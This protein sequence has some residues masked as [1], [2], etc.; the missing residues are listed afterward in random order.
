MASALESKYNCRQYQIEYLHY[1]FVHAPNDRK[2]PL[3]LICGRTLQNDSMKPSKFK[4]HLA[5]VHP[6]KNTMV[7]SISNLLQKN[8][9]G[10]HLI[11]I[12]RQGPL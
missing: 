3:C 2:I 1:G 7:W 9:K 6:S 4:R 11:L 8:V 10:V 12:L 5:Q